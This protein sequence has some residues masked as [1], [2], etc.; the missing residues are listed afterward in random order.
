[1]PTKQELEKKAA[2]MQE[3]V[4]RTMTEVRLCCI[5]DRTIAH[6]FTERYFSVIGKQELGFSIDKQAYCDVGLGKVEFA[7]TTDTGCSAAGLC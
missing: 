1:M 5:H 4:N 7:P 3:L 6:S 2:Q